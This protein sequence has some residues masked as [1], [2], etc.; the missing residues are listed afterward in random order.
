MEEEK[1]D[2]DEPDQ[3]HALSHFLAGTF[4]GMSG[5]FIG[6][7]FDTVKVR[8]Q[9][10]RK[11]KGVLPYRNALH[12]AMLCL[13]REGIRGLYR[14]LS[15]PLIGD[16]MTNSVIF[17]TYG[18]VSRSFLDEDQTQAD[19]HSISLFQIFLSGCAVGFSAGTILAP[20]E[21]VKTNLQVLTSPT[22]RKYSGPI[23]FIAKT[24]RTHGVF[25]LTRGMLSTWMRDVPAFGVYFWTYEGL[26][27]IAAG[28][29]DVESLG[30]I[31]QLLSG[32]MG[33]ITAWIVTYPVDVV[34]SRIQTD[35]SYTGVID[36][37]RRTAKTSGYLVFWKGIETT[38]IRAFPVN[39]VIF[40]TYE[41]FL[42]FM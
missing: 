24:V 12:C 2:V 42:R 6:Y 38:L 8:L 28:D 39:C 41:M 35:R 7:P 22:K 29:G 19:F 25:S 37:I 20:V 11:I 33:G 21:L 18:L 9:T 16:S 4:A 34:K 14:G 36:C 17:G 40:F 13:R 30:T 27:R 31:P 23:D 3:Q 32:G 1:S 5:V 26:R 15:S 10:Q